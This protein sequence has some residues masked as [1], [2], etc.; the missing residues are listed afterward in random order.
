V[1]KDKIDMGESINITVTVKNTGSLKGKETVL[2][3]LNDVA[4]SVPG[5]QAIK[6]FKKSSLIQARKNRSTLP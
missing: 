6:A 5:Q 1:E 3:Y 2:L 4:A